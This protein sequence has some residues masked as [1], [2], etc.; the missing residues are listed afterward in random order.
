MEIRSHRNH[1]PQTVWAALAMALLTA[2]IAASSDE[3]AFSRGALGGL[4]ALFA[5]I[6]VVVWCWRP[7]RTVRLDAHR[8][9]LVV[10]DQTRWSHRRRQIG[11][12]DVALVSVRSWQDPDPDIRPMKRFEHWVVLQTRQ[13]EEI[14]LSD[15]MQSEAQARQLCARVTELMQAG[16]QNVQNKTFDRVPDL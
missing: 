16:L 12:G 9:T 6:G 1:P 3:P 11:F 10:L 15:R 13:G 2:L 14:E 4:A 7:M 8:Q 5:L